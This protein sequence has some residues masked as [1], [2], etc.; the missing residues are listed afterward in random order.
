MTCPFKRCQDQVTHCDGACHGVMPDGSP[1][2]E[3]PTLTAR[4]MRA[5]VPNGNGRTYPLA[6]LEHCIERAKAGPIYGSLG[7]TEGTSIDL[8]KVSHT[9]HNLRLEGDYL[10]GDV[11]VLKTSSGEQLA[12]IIDECD[13]RATGT[14]T[15]QDGLVSNYTLI[16]I[17]AVSDGADL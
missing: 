15:I 5:D 2:T 11:T 12:K 7:L 10:V 14:G 6:A 16:S 3:T 8:S 9:V 1:M 13:F 17:D 4:I